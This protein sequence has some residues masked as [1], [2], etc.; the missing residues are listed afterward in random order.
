MKKQ[1]VSLR[2]MLVA[3]VYGL[4]FGLNP[5]FANGDEAPSALL[6][7][8][9]ARRT[10]RQL[11]HD[12]V[13]ELAVLLNEPLTGTGSELRP[14]WVRRDRYGRLHIRFTQFVDGLEIEGLQVMAHITADNRLYLV[15][16]SP[17][18]DLP[19]FAEPALWPAEAAELA[20][21]HAFSRTCVDADCSRPRDLYRHTAGAR[22]SVRTVGEPKPKVFFRALAYEAFVDDK[23]NGAH[24]RYIID[25]NTG[26]VLLRENLEKG[27]APSDYGYHTTVSGTIMGH[28]VD[29]ATMDS[30][31]SVTGWKDTVGDAHYFLYYKGD[32]QNEKG[33]WGVYDATAGD[34]EHRAG[35]NWGTTDRPAV[36]LA[37]NL[38]L[39]QRYITDSL[40]MYSFDG[41]G[42]FLQGDVHDGVGAG[43]YPHPHFGDGDQTTY[44]PVC[45]LD[46]V[47]HE[48]GHLLTRESSN[49]FD[50]TAEGG[51]LSESYSDIFAAAVELWSQSDSAAAYP[52]SRRGCADWL[53]GED[54]LRS[55][56]ALRDFRYPHRSREGGAYNELQRPEAASYSDG[57]F[58]WEDT[59]GDPLPIEEHRL[60]T[61]QNFAFYL[62]AQGSA[63]PD[64][65]DGHHYGA[66]SGVGIDKAA[67]VA[68]QANL[69]HLGRYV[70]FEHSREAWLEAGLDLVDEGVLSQSD[71]NA[72][73]SAW[74]AVGVVPQ[75]KFTFDGRH[76][77][78]L[79]ATNWDLKISGWQVA[80]NQT[81]T[82]VS[83][84]SIG[85]KKSG[86]SN[87][88]LQI[89]GTGGPGNWSC[90]GDTTTKVGDGIG[91][92]TGKLVLK[93]PDRTAF[94]AIDGCG[95]LMVRGKVR[96]YA[97]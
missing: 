49:I 45:V 62:L 69:Y 65:N 35:S 79:S 52:Y 90:A 95:G 96:T 3:W 71:L 7:A 73:D 8:L 93:H 28:E 33:G 51:G 20:V 68:M 64:S 81:Q 16:G 31:T 10:S 30:T 77:M 39:T 91:S 32:A 66:F 43:S 60:A 58:F 29:S 14:T 17:A 54:L 11:G 26:D 15:K 59:T 88:A 19:Q 13:A 44:Y 75:E 76:V 21:E 25:A 80:T 67:Q 56:A 37:R 72:I 50:M 78:K 2:V 23:L 34:W 42:S 86:E 18:L 55:L 53:I 48:V 27:L 9:N 94:M 36:S 22:D 61:V 85:F 41:L 70:S 47:A 87:V 6:R 57:T 5:T 63:A 46:A 97:F 74:K 24:W 83:S 40:R 92:L 82:S 84:G 4:A 12:P 1:A 38:E 89:D